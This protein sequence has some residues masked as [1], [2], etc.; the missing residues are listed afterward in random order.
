MISSINRRVEHLESATKSNSEHYEC[1]VWHGPHDDDALAI[2][3]ARH[4]TL[5]GVLIT[6]RIEYVSPHGR[7]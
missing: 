2:A 3:E 7:D 5:G 1:F 4:A 6:I